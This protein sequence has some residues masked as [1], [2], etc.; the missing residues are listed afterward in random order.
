MQTVL[1]AK[2]SQQLAPA[3]LAPQG[4]P[5]AALL[6][7]CV[8]AF[9]AAG[10]SIKLPAV[11]VDDLLEPLSKPQ[12]HLPSAADLAAARLARAALISSRAYSG[13]GERNPTNI[14]PSIPHAVEAAFRAVEAN[15]DSE[16]R[17]RLVPLA[18]DLRNTTLDNP[19]TYRDA[20]RALKRHSKI[21][22]RIEGRLD[23]M[24]AN[25]PVR[26]A[27]SRDSDGWQR[28]WARTFNAISEPLG[29]SL[30]TGFVLAPYQLGNSI[31]HYFAGFS[32]AEPLSVTGRQALALR[33]EFLA[34]HPETHLTPKFERQI[35][36]DLV[37]LEKTLAKRRFRAAERAFKKD[38][39]RLALYQAE[40][41]HEL[42]E[43]HP[44]Q[45]TELRG[46]IRKLETQIENAVA[47]LERHRASALESVVGLPAVQEA[48]K[49]LATRLLQGP[50]P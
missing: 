1:T 6:A 44:Q 41:A 42:L 36:F 21:D 20:S 39:P 29:S 28:L 17:K 47:E 40:D 3:P 50:V 49:N 22:P 18:M 9:L 11:V 7:A 2:P 12:I 35:Q 27:R 16:E 43:N 34:A 46:R 8:V 14:K 4:R 38:E 33:Q 30:I 13:G 19:I 45:N 26:L 37:K 48:E 15:A 24:I 5:R 31:L 32:N 10:C 25:D 23:R